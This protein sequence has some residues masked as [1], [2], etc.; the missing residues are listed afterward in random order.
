MCF[1]I[2]SQHNYNQNT[3]SLFLVTYWDI[4]KYRCTEQW[5]FYQPLALW[6][7]E[8]SSKLWW[9]VVAFSF[10][11]RTYFMIWKHRHFWSVL[12]K[13]ARIYSKPKKEWITG[14][15]FGTWISWL[16]MYWEFHHPNWQTHIFQRGR[17]TTNQI[18]MGTSSDRN[19]QSASVASHSAFFSDVVQASQTILLCRGAFISPFYLFSWFHLEAVSLRSSHEVR[20]E[21]G[22]ESRDC[23]IQNRVLGKC[24]SSFVMTFRR[25]DLSVGHILWASIFKVCGW[26]PLFDHSQWLGKDVDKH[27]SFLAAGPKTLLAG[28]PADL[29]GNCSDRGHQLLQA[30]FDLFSW[31]VLAISSGHVRNCAV[32]DQVLSGERLQVSMLGFISCRSPP[33]VGI[34]R[35]EKESDERRSS[36]W[37]KVE[38]F[39]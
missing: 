3:C 7:G 21:D 9:V 1:P 15:W 26:A 19:S 30:H 14:W 28:A 10:Y 8:Y 18:K 4:H 6:L 34:V 33:E 5:S 38:K 22:A 12:W 13:D 27:R 17:Y 2:F 31:H 20:H 39:K 35:E 32:H 25:P 23:S 24:S 37:K 29:Q 16:S 36:C 11:H